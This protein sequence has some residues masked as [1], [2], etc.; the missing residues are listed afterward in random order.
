VVWPHRDG[1]P[2]TYPLRD[3]PAW[4]AQNNP[5]DAR[6]EDRDCWVFAAS[7]ISW[8]RWVVTWELDQLGGF[9]QHRVLENMYLLPS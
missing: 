8:R 1:P 9:S 6:P 7:P 5:G 4:D 3:W 2:Q